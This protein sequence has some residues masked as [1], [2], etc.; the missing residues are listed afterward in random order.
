MLS[1]SLLVRSSFLALA[2]AACADVR[3][4]S[5]DVEAEIAKL[6]PVLREKFESRAGRS[7]FERALADAAGLKAEARARKLDEL[8]AIQKQVRETEDR[9]I[10]QELLKQ[11]LA[12]TVVA[13]EELKKFWQ[14]NQSLF[15]QPERVRVSRVFV[16]TR[17]DPD[18]AR[19]RAEAFKK[20]LD[21]GE[22][23]ASVAKEGEGAERVR[24]GDLGF[25]STD[26]A[27]RALAKAALALEPKQV[28][29][30]IATDGGFS[31]LVALEKQPARVVPFEEARPK[32]QAH[33]TPV[34]ERRAFEKLVTKL[35]EEDRR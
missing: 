4:E 23:L 21:G 16:A 30:V 27:D 15:Q 2:V 26:H 3:D 11:E 14:E 33:I 28:S 22:A 10:V 5:V 19:K 8:P 17:G 7:E 6:P 24:G 20:R 31:V 25:V 9:L 13:E 12:Q 34:L 29:E 32:V 1:T 18:G 35:R